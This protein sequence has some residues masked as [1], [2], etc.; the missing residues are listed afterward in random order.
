MLE[1]EQGGGFFQH[2]GLYMDWMY[3][4]LDLLLVYVHLDLFGKLSPSAKDTVVEGGS[5]LVPA[6]VTIFQIIGE[7]RGA[8]QFFQFVGVTPHV[9]GQRSINWM[10][11]F[12][13][14]ITAVVFDVGGK[15]FS[16]MFFP[17]QTQIHMEMEARER[18]NARRMER[19]NQRQQGSRPVS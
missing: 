12:F 4:R 9:L 6:A 11:I 2:F 17:T 7:K 1:K 10:L 18:T 14:P 8:G 15:V 5:N 16:N 13:A 3:I 19:R